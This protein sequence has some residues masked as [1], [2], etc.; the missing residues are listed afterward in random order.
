MS[1]ALSDHWKA[2]RFEGSVLRTSSPL[3]AASSSW[4]ITHPSEASFQLFWRGRSC[5]FC[6]GSRVLE[7]LERES[8]HFFIALRLLTRS[9]LVP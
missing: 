2:G 7:L 3:L 4:L 6:R 8:F 9:I 5:G 1:A